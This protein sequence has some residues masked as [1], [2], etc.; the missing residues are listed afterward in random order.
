MKRSP[1]H[2]RGGP[3]LDL[4][5]AILGTYVE[6]FY[7]FDRKMAL[8]KVGTPHGPVVAEMEFDA[9]ERMA[10]D[11]LNT[12]SAPDPEAAWLK[13]HPGSIRV[14]WTKEQKP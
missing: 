1:I 14:D 9:I 12:V 13:L 11:M 10:R 3:G 8:I 7:Q 6:W 5:D 4:A 2:Q